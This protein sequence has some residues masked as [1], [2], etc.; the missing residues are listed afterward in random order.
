[1]RLDKENTQLHFFWGLPAAIL[2]VVLSIWYGVSSYNAGH[3]LRGGSLP[4]LVCGIIAGGIIAF[5]MLLWPRKA[6]RAW[7]LIA[8]RHWMAAH[9]WLGIV[10][11]PIAVLHSGFHFGGWLPTIF[12]VLFTL[13]IVSGLY[14]WVLQNILPKLLFKQVPSET[15]Y[16]QIDVVSRSNVADAYALLMNTLGPPPS[17]LA[18][19]VQDDALTAQQDTEIDYRAKRRT[20]VVVGATR[21]VGRLRGRLLR[22]ATVQANPKFAKELWNAFFEMRPYLLQG[23]LA[24]SELKHSA[25]AA[26]YFSSLKLKCG[27]G[28]AD[29][30]QSLESYC[31]QRRQFD[32]QKRMHNWLHGWLPIHIGLSVAVTIL[33]VAHIVTALRYW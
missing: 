31:E 18:D 5:E 21:E 10:S 11:W 15:I 7:R 6:F 19:K 1:M 4:G 22:T 16:S 29:I 3:L 23:K 28:C 8:T 13:T 9:L 25:A 27:E 17:E 24:D 32:L 14:G 12:I 26:N 20:T 2:L 33:L 30:V